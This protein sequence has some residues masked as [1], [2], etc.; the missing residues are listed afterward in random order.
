M[1]GESEVPVTT[2]PARHMLPARHFAQR[3]RVHFLLCVALP[4]AITLTVPFIWP[5]QWFSMQ[6]VAI[7]ATMWLLVGGLGISV[8]FHRHFSHRAFTATKPVRVL[9]AVVGCMAAQGPVS[10]WVA[11][12]RC[13]HSRSDQGGDP[14]TPNPA[15]YAQKPRLKSFFHGHIGWVWSHDVPSPARFAADL[16]RDKVVINVDRFYWVLI[17]AGIA[18]PGAIGL[19]VWESHGFLKGAYWGGFVRIAVGQNIIWAVNSVCHSFGHRPFET[20]DR[21]RNVWWLSVISFGESWHN[22]HH[23]FPSS[24][25]LGYGV[26]QIDIGWLLIRAMAPFGLVGNIRQGE[27]RA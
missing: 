26:K 16:L 12:H 13:H 18:L 5:S 15:A 2:S 9:L 4:T 10:Y 20:T 17:L 19:L 23:Q 6:G 3:Q 1:R 25:R 24:A 21:S 22:N 11:L 7:W 14:H 8:G 27:P